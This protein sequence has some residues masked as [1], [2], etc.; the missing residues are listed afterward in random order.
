MA[1][2]V[3]SN[4]PVTLADRVHK[5][6]QYL[7]IGKLEKGISTSPMET[8]SFNAGNKWLKIQLLKNKNQLI[9][10]SYLYSFYSL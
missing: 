6:Y 10:L 9:L 3:V 1:P 8:N 4:L 5:S 2:V 7:Q